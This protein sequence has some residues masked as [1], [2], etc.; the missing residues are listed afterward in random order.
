M[1]RES[2]ISIMQGDGERMARRGGRP[3]VPPPRRTY[4][5]IVVPLAVLV[6]L[7]VIWCGV[8]YY[9]AGVANRTLTG[10]MATE[11]AAGRVYTCGQEGIAGFPL[12]IQVRRYRRG[13]R[14]LRSPSS[15]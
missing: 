3:P 11:A 9:A 10:W 4:L 8:W 2:P 7:A 1:T 13:R 6:G 5:R 14:R 12:S 15:R